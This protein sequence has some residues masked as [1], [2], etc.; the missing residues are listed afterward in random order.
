MNLTWLTNQLTDLGLP[1]VAAQPIAVTLLFLLVLVVAIIADTLVR[2]TLLRFVLRWIQKSNFKWDDPLVKSNFFSR[3]CWFVPI[4]IFSV[5]IE[6]FL[7]HDSALYLLAHRLVM[8]G[9]VIIS[10]LSISALLNSINEIN[11]LLSKNRR[12]MLQG[13][14]DVGKIIA[15]VLSVI[16]L[17]S[18]FTGQSPWGI[19]SILGGLT[20]ITMLVFKDTILGFVASLQLSATDMIRIG[21]WIE[22]PKY[23]A[24]GDIISMSIHTV[25]V[26]NWDKTITTIPTYALVSSSFKNWRGMTESG[27]RRI[28][29]A[30]TIDLHSIH[31]CTDEMIDKLS[32]VEILK[33]YLKRKE[34]EIAKYNDQHPTDT[35]TALNGRR[36]T[37]IGIFRAYIFAY[38]KN[39]ENLHDKMTF[40]VRQLAPT[41]HGLPLEIYVFSKDQAWANYEAIQ[42][43]IFDHLLAAAPEFGLRVFQLP[44][45]YDLRLATGGGNHLL[46]PDT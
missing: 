33:D 18:I 42:A 1:G 15:Y 3:I 13:Y 10:V 45:G 27:G 17:I 9:F 24:D 35:A 29:R 46:K 25:R 21:D 43:D 34:T 44:S 37:N 39:N 19:L 8:S 20:A 11:R 5:T 30:I 12:S 31:F 16:F 38:L 2:K 41:D 26:Q 14:I 28:K 36:Q 40:L 6:S 22:M 32:G 7:P 4:S 23:G